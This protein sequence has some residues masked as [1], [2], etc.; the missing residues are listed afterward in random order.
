MA[1]SRAARFG[2]S[3]ARAI[4]SIPSSIHAETGWAHAA[5]ASAEAGAGISDAGAAVGTGIGGAEPSRGSTIGCA[6]GMG[7]CAS[8]IEVPLI[9][10]VVP[11]IGAAE[12]AGAS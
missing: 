12:D 4:A 9:S 5:C 7:A 2:V 10:V 8:L 3:R 6:V 11:V 1:R